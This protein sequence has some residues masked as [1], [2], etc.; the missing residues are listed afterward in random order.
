[1]AIFD[2]ESITVPN[3][4]LTDTLSTTWIGT[5]QPISVS[6]ASNLADDPIFLCDEDPQSLVISF[7]TTLELLASKSKTEMR[8]KFESIEN[9]IRKKLNSLYEKIGHRSNNQVTHEYEDECIEDDENV[10]TQ[11]LRTQ[12]NKLIELLEH[13]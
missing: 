9:I 5:H 7:V 13:Y 4:T 1:M 3:T 6:I 10:S 8:M 12:K 2:F 11:F